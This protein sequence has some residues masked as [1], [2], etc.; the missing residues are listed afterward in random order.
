MPRYN[1]RLPDGRWQVFSSVV[2]NFI[3][4]PMT[5]DELRE[6]RR[7]EA[8]EMADTETAS[9][10][11]ARPRINTMRY[12]DAIEIIEAVH[13][14]DDTPYG[15]NPR[16][17]IEISASDDLLYSPCPSCHMYDP[18]ADTCTRADGE[19]CAYAEYAWDEN[20]R[21]WKEIYGR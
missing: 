18:V 19:A 21:R 20:W 2:D 11:T 10:L 13:G 12:E 3:T 6:F 17:A 8:I 1:V 16:V 7:M 9:L 4:E 15:V 5:F 14:V